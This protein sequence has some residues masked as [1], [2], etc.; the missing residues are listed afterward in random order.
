MQCMRAFSQPRLVHMRSR[1]SL[2]EASSSAQ[3]EEI[4]R[5]HVAI[6][7]QHTRA[8]NIHTRVHNM[9]DHLRVSALA[10]L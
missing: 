9:R 7:K 3:I 1:K 8:H 6:N 5:A 4:T 10:V 2:N